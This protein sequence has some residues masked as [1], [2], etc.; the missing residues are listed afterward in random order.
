[1][2][3]TYINITVSW[4]AIISLLLMPVTVKAESPDG[5]MT[6]TLRKDTFSW[7]AKE[8]S[9]KKVANSP[10]ELLFNAARLG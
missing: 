6:E 7:Y 1:M 3:R 10:I 4:L 2:R 9:D 8:F 5:A